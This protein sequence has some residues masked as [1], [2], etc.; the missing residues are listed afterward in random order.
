MADSHEHHTVNPTPP[1]W[2]DVLLGAV[3]FWLV[4]EGVYLLLTTMVPGL[5]N[6]SILTEIQISGFFFLL[7]W[8]ILGNGVIAR[9][10]DAAIERERKTTGALERADE[11]RKESSR[12][13]GELSDKMYTARLE[14]AKLRDAHVTE[15]KQKADEI[16]T[17]A[18]AQSDQEIKKAMG[19]LEGN[20]SS[21][22]G[23][24]DS[25]VE[26]LARLMVEKSLENKPAPVH[27]PSTT[28][29]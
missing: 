7:I 20:V 2:N 15:A 16:S 21:V 4:T 10:V 24:L 9:Y 11:L 1:G 25:E 28:A 22:R 17:E 12:L 19:E 27:N 26:V 29:G 18:R 3:V 13:A 23:E 8:P 14:G 6:R 5:I